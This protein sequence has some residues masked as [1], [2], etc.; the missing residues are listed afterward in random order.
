MNQVTTERIHF[1]EWIRFKKE[2][3]R[4]PYS[5]AKAQWDEAI[6]KASVEEKKYDGPVDS[7]GKRSV[8]ATQIMNAEQVTSQD[9]IF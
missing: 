8:I 7:T 5:D 1:L 4:Y 9:I 2:V 6:S 3:K